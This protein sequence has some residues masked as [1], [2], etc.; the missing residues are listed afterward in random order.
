MPIEDDPSSFV[1]KE[2]NRDNLYSFLRE[3]EFN[4]L[5]SQAIS[6]Y[7]EDNTSD[8]SSNIKQTKVSKIDTKLYKSILSEKDLD[9]L[10]DILNTKSFISIDTETSSLN[11]LEAELIGISFS[12][13]P[14]EAYYIPLGHKNIKGLN[15]ELVLKKIKPLLEDP[16]IKKVGQNIKYDF[17][18]LTQ[19]GIEIDPVMSSNAC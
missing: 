17:I 10:I 16:S 15:K 14:N 13:A 1:I 12:Y 2:V 4:R 6:F 19:N 3:M 11:P 5:L 18:I 7:G 8:F 9:K